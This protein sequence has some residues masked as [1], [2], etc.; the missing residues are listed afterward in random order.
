MSAKAL[1]GLYNNITPKDVVRIVTP[2][3]RFA[4]G[5]NHVNERDSYNE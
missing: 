1:Q 2:P 3:F 4:T 5:S